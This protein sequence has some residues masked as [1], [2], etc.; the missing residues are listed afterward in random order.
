MAIKAERMG[1]D[2]RTPGQGVKVIGSLSEQC[3]DLSGFQTGLQVIGVMANGISKIAQRPLVIPELLSNG[4]KAEQRV[5]VGGISSERFALS[6]ISSIP[7]QRPQMHRQ[8]EKENTGTWQLLKPLTA[9]EQGAA[10]A[11]DIASSVIQRDQTVS[12]VWPARSQRPLRRRGC[13]RKAITFDTLETH[14]HCSQ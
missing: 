6:P 11:F 10:E 12:A 8:F 4:A 3:R 7:F 2:E 5:G 14:R 13:S 9:R 1:T